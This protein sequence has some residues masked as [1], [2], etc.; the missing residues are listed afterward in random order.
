MFTADGGKTWVNKLQNSGIDFPAG[1]WGWKIQFL[2][3]QVGFVSLEN[4][5]AAAILKTTD[6]GE[7]WKRIP[8]TD[9]QRNVELEG[10]GFINEQ[11][12]MGRR[13][14]PRLHVGQS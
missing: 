7:S 9:P 1:E 6:G 2:T 13:M 3:P 4:D 14:G 11:G 5:T 10:I 8:I 12:R